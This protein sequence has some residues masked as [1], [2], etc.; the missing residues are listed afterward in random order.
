MEVIHEESS[1]YFEK[2]KSKKVMTLL[3]EGHSIT[4][5]FKKARFLSKELISYIAIAEKSPNMRESM[6]NILE[7]L[8][9]R[10]NFLKKSK[11]QISL[12]ILYFVL[13]LITILV[14]KFYAID[15]QLQE[16][17][18]YK[19]I[20]KAQI[21]IHL[22]NASMYADII[23][24]ILMVGMFLLFSFLYSIFGKSFGLQIVAKVIVSYIPMMARVS[25]YFEKFFILSLLG[26]ILKSG[27]TLPKSLVITKDA[28]SNIKI[29]GSIEE[30]IEKIKYGDKSYLV[31]SGLFTNIQKGLF[32][33]VRNSK[34]LGENFLKLGQT[35]KD[36]AYF[37]ATKF[38]RFMTIFSIAMLAM[39]V[40]LE[41]YSVVMTQMIV[42]KSY[43]I[44]SLGS[45][46]GRFL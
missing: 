13:A 3:K 34:E 12:P 11:E 24:G 40:L 33:G 10:N 45:G 38:F 22:A 4:D 28:V 39:T 37:N 16:A 2:R 14:V 17:T 7:Y 29:K 1:D 15:Y 25:D 35:S 9:D 42:Q 8:E 18:K 30:M 36:D 31:D 21:D 20:I 26:Q 44:E 19:G 43:M 41:F 5:S 23:F 32:L 27:V 6:K 46:A